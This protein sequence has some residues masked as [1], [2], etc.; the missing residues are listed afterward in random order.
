MRTT[1]RGFVIYDEFTDRYGSTIRV[2]E[3][4]LAD[5][6]AVWIFH[7]NSDLTAM[8]HLTREQATRLRDALGA[9]LKAS[10]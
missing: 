9:F 6:P 2:Q 8:P 3:S 4:S 7:E 1:E 5:E 10:R